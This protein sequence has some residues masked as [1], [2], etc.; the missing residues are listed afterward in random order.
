L[1]VFLE[2][3]DT[4]LSFSHVKKKECTYSGAHSQDK[5]NNSLSYKPTSATVAK[6]CGDL[7][8]GKKTSS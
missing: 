8:S 5:I 4:G 2:S 6:C 7:L 3:V 1:S